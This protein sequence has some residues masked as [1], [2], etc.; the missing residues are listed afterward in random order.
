MLR[1]AAALAAGFSLA[2][3]ATIGAPPQ[4]RQSG[5]YA[6]YLI[7]RVANER[8]DHTAAADRYF[9][10]LTRA[11]D[12]ATLLNGALVASLAAGDEARAR[13]AAR[14]AAR[15]DAPAY[16]HLIRGADAIVARRWNVAGRELQQAE[17]LAAEELVARMLLVW[18]RTGEGRVDDVTVDLAPLAQ[19]RPYGG[20]FAYQQAMALD[21]AG[22]R[23]EALSA[24]ETALQGGLWLPAGIERHA[25]LLVRMGD[26]ENAIRLLSAEV[27]RPNPALMAALERV[28]AGSAAAAEP[29]TPARGAA[30]GLY[31]I[32][33]VFLQESDSTNGLAALTLALMLDPAFD[34]ARLAFAQQQTRIGH[35]DAA[36]R[37]LAS[38]SA[39]SPYHGSARVMESWALLDSGA[40]AEAIALAQANAESGDTRATRTLADMYRNLGRYDEAEPI[41]TRLIAQHGDDWRLYFARANARERLGRWPEAEA[42]LQRALELSPEQPDVMNYLGYSWVDRGENLQ[43]GLAMIRRAVDLRPTSGAIIDSLGW[44]YYRMGDYAQALDQLERAVEIEPADPTLNDHLGDVYWRLGRRIEARFQWQRALTLEPDNAEAIRAKL[45]NGLPAPAP[46]HSANR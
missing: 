42:D 15:N 14:M 4:P 40:E 35:I 31:G 20:L 41:Y 43:E 17:G 3:C 5:A 32:S 28:Q 44:A 27:N 29:L 30:I 36:R 21:Y 34:G 12:D 25:D 11:P 33:A 22:R 26:R 1:A 38:V 39:D 6:D 7:G 10:A 37:M 46:S 19:I 13:R 16:A 24:Y 18:A 8:N 9:A 45:E 23:E 2:A